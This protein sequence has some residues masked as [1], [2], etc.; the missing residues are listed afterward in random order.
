MT[1]PCEVVKEVR[2]PRTMVFKKDRPESVFL[3]FADP[4]HCEIC[5]K[6]IQWYCSNKP[7]AEVD[8]K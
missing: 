6:T 8:E 7:H 4:S 1:R 3:S 5:K 2:S